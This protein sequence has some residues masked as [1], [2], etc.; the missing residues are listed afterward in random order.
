MLSAA[1]CSIEKLL[2][3]GNDEWREEESEFEKEVAEEEEEAPS[4]PEE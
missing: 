2:V 3:E 4:D 1:L